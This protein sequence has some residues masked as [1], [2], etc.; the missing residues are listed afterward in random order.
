MAILPKFDPSRN[1]AAG[2][3]FRFNGII[4][5]RHDPFPAE[6]EAPPDPRKLRQLF[7]SRHLVYDEDKAT[8]VAPLK[9]TPRGKAAAGR[10]ED[11]ALKGANDKP[12]EDERPVPSDEAKALSKKHNHD[13]LFT[14]ASGLAGVTKD[15]TKA[16]IAQA[17]I[18]SGR[19]ADGTA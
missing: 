2:K 13:T 9:T 10:L 7:E 11:E 12:P 16:Q 15:W 3:G 8:Q 1:F 19:A 6:G 5:N 18:D 4:Y 17:L 14:K